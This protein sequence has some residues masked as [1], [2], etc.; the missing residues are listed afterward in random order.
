MQTNKDIFKLESQKSSSSNQKSNRFENLIDLIA[1][2]NYFISFFLEI[3]M[4][5]KQQYLYILLNLILI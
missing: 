1:A 3:C 2:K 4:L 5:K